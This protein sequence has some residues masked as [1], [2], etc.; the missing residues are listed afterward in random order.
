MIE[1]MF[2]QWLNAQP[3]GDRWMLVIIATVLA[4]AGFIGA[5]YYFYRKRLIEDTPTSTIQA[6]AQGYVEF[7]GVS[8]LME[9]PPITAPLT[10]RTCTWYEYRIEARR[11]DRWREIKAGRSEELFLLEDESGECIVDPEGA[12]VTGATKQVWY[13]AHRHGVRPGRTSLLG[14][15]GRYRYTERR[16][17]PGDV[18]YAIGLF[19]TI[20]GSA[21]GKPDVNQDVGVLIREWK[22]DSQA[23]LARFDKNSDGNIDVDEWQAVRDEAY[24][25]VM[26]RHKEL[27]HQPATNI[28]GKT[29]DKRRPYL[30][31]ALPQSALIRRWHYYS[32]A[33]ITLFFISGSLAIWI[34][35]LI[36]RS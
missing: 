35:N 27:Q 31:S 6:A 19:K 4:I 23:M 25:Q 18:L 20:G 16:M 12:R 21:G 8:K 10:G 26:L 1:S 11:G 28:I 29:Q 17:H 2:A 36:T 32:V 5:F 15:F 30:L 3:V 22:R 33:L 9:G 7:S 14:R 34:F 13:G 24:K